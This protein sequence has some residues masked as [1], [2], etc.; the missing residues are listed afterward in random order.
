M[1]DKKLTAEQS[2]DIITKM[3]A[4]TRNRYLNDGSMFMIWG[5]I[6]IVGCVISYVTQNFYPFHY[7]GYI[8]LGLMGLGISVTIF[9]ILKRDKRTGYRT[10]LDVL[11]QVLWLGFM[12]SFF[13]IWFFI[14]KF[15]TDPSLFI[16]VLL[17]LSTCVSG[18]LMQFKPLYWGG[19]IFWLGA[20][21]GSFISQKDYALLT[22]VAMLFGYLIPGWLLK[23]HVKKGMNV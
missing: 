23:Q 21:I 15:M 12:I 13:I 14:G 2:L 17:G 7:M 18:A 8:W 16:M 22:A 1:E 4:N 11:G 9:K 10:Q 20:I 6:V 5:I 19:V 3:I